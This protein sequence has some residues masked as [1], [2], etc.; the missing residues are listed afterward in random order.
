MKTTS[1]KADE[2]TRDW[3]LIDAEDQ[4]FG[5]ESVGRPSWKGIC[6]KR[7]RHREGNYLVH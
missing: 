6:G 1:I 7:T 5:V 2:I 4:I 3:Y